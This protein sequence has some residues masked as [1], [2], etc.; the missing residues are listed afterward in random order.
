MI[1]TVPSII[2]ALLL[3]VVILLMM[4]AF[5]VRYTE[6]AVVTRFDQIKDAFA[7]M[8]SGAHFGKVAIAIG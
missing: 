2:V 5:Q 6:T 7:H 4:C 1:K 3:I 8:E